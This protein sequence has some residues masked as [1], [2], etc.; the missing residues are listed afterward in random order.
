MKNNKN[1][2]K[3]L[4]SMLEDNLD[5][6][7][8]VYIDDSNGRYEHKLIP[9]NGDG[10]CYKCIDVLITNGEVFESDEN[11]SLVQDSD[12]VVIKSIVDRNVEKLSYILSYEMYGLMTSALLQHSNPELF[13]KFNS[14]SKGS[15]EEFDASCNVESGFLIYPVV[16][17]NSRVRS[18]GSS[19]K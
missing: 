16:D 19:I 11:A 9:N 10:N 15:L 12:Y 1:G 13:M 14:S 2:C 18:R 17:V 5:K 7:I 3:R 8:S 6:D 4:I